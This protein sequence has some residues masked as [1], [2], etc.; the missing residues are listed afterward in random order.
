MLGLFGAAARLFR[1]WLYGARRNQPEARQ[2]DGSNEGPVPCQCGCSHG[3]AP[4][5]LQGE[6]RQAE[7]RAQ[8]GRRAEDAMQKCEGSAGSAGGK[9][10][11]APPGGK[12]KP[13]GKGRKGKPKGK[14]KGKGRKGKPKGKGRKGKPKH[15]TNGKILPL[16]FVAAMVGGACT[17]LEFMA[18]MAGDT[19]TKLAMSLLEALKL[20]VS[21]KPNA[22][23]DTHDMYRILLAVFSHENNQSSMDGVYK[24]GPGAGGSQKADQP[25]PGAGDHTRRAARLHAEAVRERGGPLDGARQAARDAAAAHRRGNRHA[26]HP[27][28]REGPHEVRRILKVREGHQKV[29]PPGHHTLRGGG[30]TPDPGG[31]GGPP[32]GRDRRRGGAA[33]AGV[34]QA[35]HTR[36]LPGDGPRV[37]FRR[38]HVQGQK[39]GHTHSH[40]RRQASPD[41]RVHPRVRRGGARGHI[42]THDDVRVGPDRLVQARNREAPKSYEGG[43]RRGQKA[44]KTAREGGPRTTDKYHVFATTMPDS[45]IDDDPDKVAEFYRIR[46]G[47]ENSYKSYEQMRPR[48][49]SRSYSVRFLLTIM[50][51]VFYNIWTLAR[52]MEARRAGVHN[53]AR[54][55]AAR[56]AR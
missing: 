6:A 26:R 56:R 44:G 41:Q 21:D 49:T 54:R 2:G 4:P 38:R 23:Y 25:H 51:F 14:P 50:P 24:E 55:T 37:P 42:G 7:R 20:P 32:G 43:H 30:A 31:G 53:E 9:G 22:K 36:A 18:V 17:P 11:D 45:W 33:A 28:V 1:P 15:G 46:W 40:A 39:D 48:T 19:G 8:T 29:R 13:K 12:G 5:I 34:P 47:I 27:A 3:K 10:R 16:E 52:F 35:R